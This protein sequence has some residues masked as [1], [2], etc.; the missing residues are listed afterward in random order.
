MEKIFA[1]EELNQEAAERALTTVAELP[2]TGWLSLPITDRHEELARIQA[3]ATQIQNDSQALVCIGV[4]GSY[5]GHKALIE[6]LA[7]ERDEH[8]VQVLYAGN[9]LDPTA[10]QEVVATLADRDF[11]VNIISKSGTTTEVLAAW[12]ILRELL[13]TKY[14]EDWVRRVYVTT[15]AA[16]GQLHNEAVTHGYTRFVLPDDVG[17]RYS[18]LSDVG[19]LPLAAAGVDI[20]GLLAG[21]RDEHA[22]IFANTPTASV[23]FTDTHDQTTSGRAAVLA[24]ALTRQ[25]LYRAGND[26]EVF[27][28]FRLRLGGV[29]AWWQQLFGESEGKNQQG[30]FPATAVYT[31]D[32][33][34]LGQFMQQGRRNLFETILTTRTELAPGWT[35]PADTHD[36]SGWLDNKRLSDLNQAAETATITAHRA[37][38]IAVGVITTPD[39]SARGL[40]ALIFYLETACAVSALLAGV[41]PFDQPGVEAYKHEMFRLLGKTD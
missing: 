40:G 2:M 18:V 36:G 10:M 25:Q 41:N 13:Q 21:A 5:L 12:R 3:A 4:G 19:L 34:S 8:G 27:A 32:L 16:S 31:T 29:A 7:P 20:Q 11:S 14:Q 30:I 1:A 26:T 15:D 39:F 35:V 9:S 38:G 22:A 17:G 37:G 24:Y 6:A 33:H 23:E 28:S